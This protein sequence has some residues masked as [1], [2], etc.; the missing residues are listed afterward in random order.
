MDETAQC[1]RQ[2]LEMAR[3]VGGETASGGVL[4]LLSSAFK[5][6]PAVN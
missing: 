6:V 4:T 5:V 1:R 3:G 2:M